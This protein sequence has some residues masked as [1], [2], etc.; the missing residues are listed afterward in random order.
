MGALPTAI[1]LIHAPPPAR[2]SS[3]SPVL[4]APRCLWSAHKGPGPV[5]VFIVLFSSLVVALALSVAV[6]PTV[7]CS[8]LGW[9]SVPTARRRPNVPVRPADR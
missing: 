5:F 4:H 6:L 8:G 3:P 9:A 1:D 7:L 2:P